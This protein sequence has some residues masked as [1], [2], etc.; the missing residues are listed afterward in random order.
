[1]PFTL[2]LVSLSV[3]PQ[4]PDAPNT[5]RLALVARWCPRRGLAGWPCRSAGRWLMGAVQTVPLPGGHGLVSP[6]PPSPLPLPPCSSFPASPR[7]RPRTQLIASHHALGQWTPHH[8]RSSHHH[9]LNLY[10]R[11]DQSLPIALPRPSAAP[12]RTVQSQGHN[13]YPPHHT[14][15]IDQRSEFPLP[16]ACDA[17][18][19]VPCVRWWQRQCH[20]CFQMPEGANHAMS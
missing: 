6:P 2:A 3:T 18:C 13:P 7:R 5:V 15:G 1:M 16:A 11:Q 10:Q 4:K 19:A 12:P 20:P 14:P 9:P 17:P 8:Y